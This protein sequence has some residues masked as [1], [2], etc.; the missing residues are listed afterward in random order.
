[1]LEC[2]IRFAGRNATGVNCV[3]GPRHLRDPGLGA[4]PAQEA[5]SHAVRTQRAEAGAERRAEGGSG[6][7]PPLPAWCVPGRPRREGEGGGGGG[8]AVCTM[9][10]PG[11]PGAG[12][13]YYPGGVSAARAGWWPGRNPGTPRTPRGHAGPLCRGGSAGASRPHP[14]LLP[15]RCLAPGRCPSASSWGSLLPRVPLPCGWLR[16]AE[17]RVGF[18]PRS[19]PCDFGTRGVKLCKFAS[20]PSGFPLRATAILISNGPGIHLPSLKESGIKRE[21]GGRPLE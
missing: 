14:G 21:V 15:A 8:G 1:M 16:G 12:G 10:Y 20:F 5:R 17:A 2:A 3:A 13:G 4:T 11:H 9:A 7:R 19:P 6:A 18:D